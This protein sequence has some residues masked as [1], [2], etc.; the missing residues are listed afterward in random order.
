MVNREGNNV[1]KFEGNALE[2]ALGN[3]KRN[4]NDCSRSLSHAILPRNAF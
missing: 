2:S 1:V 4:R 3:V